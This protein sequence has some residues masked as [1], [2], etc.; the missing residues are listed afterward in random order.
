MKTIRRIDESPLIK[1]E[2]FS[3]IEF[4]QAADLLAAGNTEAHPRC[5]RCL[6]LWQPVL[7]PN[8]KSS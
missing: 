8:L 5:P 1:H 6:L 7:D 2:S 4:I 3:R